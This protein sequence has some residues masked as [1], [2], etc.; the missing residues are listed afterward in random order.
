MHP[1]RSGN[2]HNHAGNNG[3]KGLDIVID[4]NRGGHEA[5]LSPHDKQEGEEGGGSNDID[6]FAGRTEAQRGPV[7][8]R[9]VRGHKGH[10]HDAGKG[11]RPLVECE[12]VIL[13]DYPREIGQIKGIA[14]LGN[15]DEQVTTKVSSLATDCRRGTGDE[16]HRSREAHDDA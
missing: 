7:D 6:D 11:K 16:Q 1:L 15:E 10:N 9:N 3:D 8:L 5:A 2:A 4:A 13:A 14:H 12:S